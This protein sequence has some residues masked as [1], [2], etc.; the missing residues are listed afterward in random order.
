[1]RF[2]TSAASYW[3]GVKHAHQFA[4]R[5]GGYSFRSVSVTNQPL[6]NG[7]RGRES[8]DEDASDAKLPVSTES[9]L[10]AIGLHRDST[11]RNHVSRGKGIFLGFFVFPLQPSR[12]ILK[13]QQGCI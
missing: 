5:I 8:C 12:L 2:T 6:G 13:V 9:V 10:C 4:S 11:G 1:M 3:P 7:G